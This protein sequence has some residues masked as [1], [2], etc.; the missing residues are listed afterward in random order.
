MIYSPVGSS[1]G[2]PQYVAFSRSSHRIELSDG[3]PAALEIFATNGGTVELRSAEKVQ[4]PYHRLKQ[5]GRNDVQE[6]L[7]SRSV[8]RVASE[9]IDAP[10]VHGQFRQSPSRVFILLAT[11]NGASYLS[12]QLASLAKQTHENWVLYWRDDGSNDDTVAILTEFAAMI[13]VGRCVRVWEPTGRIR[14]AGSFM[15]LLRAA[16]PLLGAGDSVAFV[17]QDDVWLPDKLTRGFAALAAVDARI[18]ALYCARLMVV[19]ARLRRL[20]ETT[21]SPRRCGFPASLTQ[22]VAAGCTIMLNRRAADLV[23]ASA[24]PSASPHDWWCYLL[25]TAAG[26]QILVDNAIVALYR[27]HGGNAIGAPPSQMRRAIAA[28]RRGPRI[29]MNVLRQHLEALAAQPDLLSETARPTVL[30]LHSALSGSLFD[31]L[32]ALNTPDLR[33]QTW[34][35]TLLFRLW[36][37]VG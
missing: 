25:V 29:F 2:I 35:E 13:G 33:R 15:A 27:Q 30:R 37:L 26:G 10:T 4:I 22:N 20:T 11:Y 17:D 1:G 34:L 14:P 24:P 23:A 9:I 18:P 28:L 5:R 36:F 31:K 7:I 6:T 21:I 8:E 32:A 19:N 16:A 12:A 3:N